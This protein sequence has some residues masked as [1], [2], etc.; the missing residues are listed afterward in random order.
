MNATDSTI[1]LFLENAAKSA[2]VMH[3]AA[4]A[5]EL[6]TILS[7][8][9]A[10][11][12]DVFCPCV[13]ELEK[14]SA[15]GRTRLV[16]DYASAGVTVEEVSAAIAETGSIVCASS[17]GKAVQAS[18]LPSQ[19]VAIVPRDRI[20]ATLDDFFAV[21]AA[22][23]PTN[24]TIITGPSRTADIELNLVIGVHGP[25]RLDIIVV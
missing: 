6:L 9:V 23:P 11:D 25:E 20:F 10:Q 22:A 5:E 8:I 1:A 13:T 2:A 4:S 7:E 15:A 12:A 17:G 19:H 16:H 18:L 24:L 3:R 14:T 21:H